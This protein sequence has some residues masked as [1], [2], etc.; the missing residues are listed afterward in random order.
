MGGQSL[1]LSEIARSIDNRTFLL[2]DQ[3]S[4]FFRS[5]SESWLFV[6]SISDI[7]LRFRDIRDQTRKLSETAS[8]FGRFLPYQILRGAVPL[9]VVRALGLSSILSD[10]SRGKL[11]WDYSP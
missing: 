9:N 1:T 11:S 8:N 4:H 10:T 5:N 7:K 6:I 2:V 3:I